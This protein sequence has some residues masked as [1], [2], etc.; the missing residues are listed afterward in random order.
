MTLTSPRHEGSLGTT[1]LVANT[2]SASL[3]TQTRNSGPWIL[4]KTSRVGLPFTYCFIE[5][6][7]AISVTETQ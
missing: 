6:Y 3:R 7:F 4:R 5:A 2:M 1:G